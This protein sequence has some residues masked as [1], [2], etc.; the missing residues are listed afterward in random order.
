M[1]L[2]PAI[3]LI[4]GRCVRLYNGRFEEQTDFGNPIEVVKEFVDS[5][6]LWIHVVDLSAAKSGKQSQLSV[7]EDLIKA[8]KDVNVQVGG[9]VRDDTAAKA[10]LDIGASR[11][12][13]GTIGI[14][15]PELGIDLASR[16]PKKVALGIDLKDNFVA[17]KG[18]TQSSSLT[19]EG[20]LDVFGD[21]LELFGALIVTD[22]SK[23]GAL[24]GPNKELLL[25][26]LSLVKIPVIASGGVS[27]LSDLENLNSI[28]LDGTK[29]Q[30]AIVGMAIHQR[31]FSVKE[32][33]E[34]CKI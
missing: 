22:I 28:D 5:G 19:L 29:L 15:N 23:D 9:G 10:L 12:V 4:D 17:I 18:W 21:R 25:K 14:E 30:G 13:L 6:A 2:F 26:V 33:I 16:W 8:A 27:S 1:I 3:D 24:K 31:I 34:V 11:V 20:A 7:I 32:A